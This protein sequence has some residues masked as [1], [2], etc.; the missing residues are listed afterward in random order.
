M[1]KNLRIHYLFPHLG[2]DPL[3]WAKWIVCAF[4]FLFLPNYGSAQ[5]IRIDIDIPA[6]TGVS[7]METTDLNWSSTDSHSQQLLEGSYALTLSSSENLQVIAILNH[8]EYLINDAGSAIPLSAVLAFRNDGQNK[9]PREK[10]SDQVEFPMSN[11]GLLIENM[12]DEP[13]VLNAHIM[14]FTSIDKPAI[15]SS[16]YQGD[17]RLTIEYN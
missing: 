17:I 9:P 10:A 16:I 6:K 7:D 2:M 14:V 12:K 5:F 11:S 1:N 4:I 3:V 15:S 8:S 13:Q